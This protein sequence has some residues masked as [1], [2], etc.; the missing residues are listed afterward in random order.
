M[1]HTGAA[2]HLPRSLVHLIAPATGELVTEL[3]V[4]RSERALQNLCLLDV[5]DDP[6]LAAFVAELVS[7][8]PNKQWTVDLLFAD[9]AA[10]AF[11]DGVIAAARS[12][13]GL[14]SLTDL[15]VEVTSDGRSAFAKL[16]AATPTFSRFVVQTDEV[17]G[18]TMCECE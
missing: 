10:D 1:S 15:Q 11:C 3:L 17:C 8:D 16:L 5:I 18:L 4:T 6:K 2:Q 9:S 13:T 7:T 14:P 12:G